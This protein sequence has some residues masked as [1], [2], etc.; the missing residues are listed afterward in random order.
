MLILLGFVATAWVV[1]I[2]LSA[3]D[4]T[5]HIVENPLVPVYF[6]DKE[7]MITLLLLATLGAIFLRGFRRLSE[8]RCSWWSTCC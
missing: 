4:A 2:T 5:A 8:S 3:A 1:T 7:V 6:H